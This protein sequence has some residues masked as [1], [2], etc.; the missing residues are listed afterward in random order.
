MTY[1]TS[2]AGFATYVAVLGRFGRPADMA[3]PL[4]TIRKAGFGTDRLC[5]RGG[6]VYVFT[7]LVDEAEAAELV[8]AFLAGTGEVISTGAAADGAARCTIDPAL[9]AA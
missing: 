4:A 2:P 5:G 3:A 7:T 6:I 8:D 1:E 9:I